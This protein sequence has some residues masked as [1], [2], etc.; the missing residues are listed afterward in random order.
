MK[1]YIACQDFNF[2]WSRKDLD[3]VKKAYKQ[4][5]HIYDISKQV[6]R[7][8]HEVAIL[9]IDLGRNSKI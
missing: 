1:N 6:N 2:F 4:K 3:K 7:P 5:L 8:I 9:I